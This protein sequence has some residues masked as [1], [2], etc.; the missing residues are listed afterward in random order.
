M[1]SRPTPRYPHNYVQLQSSLYTASG[2]FCFDR[3]NGNT[4]RNATD[5]TFPSIVGSLSPE[6][7]EFVNGANLTEV[8]NPQH[9]GTSW[10]NTSSREETAR[11]SRASINAN[12]DASTFT[13]T[14]TQTYAQTTSGRIHVSRRRCWAT[15]AALCCEGRAEARLGRPVERHAQQ[16]R[17]MES[18]PFH[19]S[20]LPLRGAGVAPARSRPRLCAHEC[21]D[22]AAAFDALSWSLGCNIA[23]RGPPETIMCVCAHLSNACM[24]PGVFTNPDFPWA[25]GN[26]AACR[27]RWFPPPRTWRPREVAPRLSATPA[28]RQLVEHN[29]AARLGHTLAARRP[30]AAAARRI[31]VRGS[32][33]HATCGGTS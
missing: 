32:P 7:R 22:C 2:L 24:K 6:C 18:T 19:A 31:D 3:G 13:H 30:E 15:A 27:A 1:V 26:G 23:P 28:R 8:G 5:R 11:T 17:L 25:R 20:G 14:H 33:A 16:Q 12:P 10:A 4:P 9:S 21:C 29:K